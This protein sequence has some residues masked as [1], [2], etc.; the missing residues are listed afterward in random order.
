MAD[1]ARGYA[2]PPSKPYPLSVC[3]GVLAG[4]SVVCW[5]GILY[6]VTLL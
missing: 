2:P 1:Q 3:V 5:A 4:L 6:V